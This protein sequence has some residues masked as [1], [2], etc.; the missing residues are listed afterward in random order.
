[1]A[2]N[3]PR[4]S[5]AFLVF[6][7]SSIA[8]A[9]VIIVVCALLANKP[10]VELVDAKRGQL[11]IETREKLE[12]INLEQ[13]TTAGWVDKEKGVVRLPIEDAM[14]LVAANLGGKKPAP[15]TV[16]I[17]P[18]LPM[19]APYDPNAAEPAPG[20]LPS[21]PQGSDTIRFDRP[22]ATPSA[23]VV[24]VPETLTASAGPDRAPL[25]HWTEKSEPKK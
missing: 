10:K 12:K 2:D 24:P 20:A 19:P 15:S 5:N 8:L 3:E 18:P 22:A 7:G 25:I 9:T 11:R 13:L 23:A 21:S 4:Q 16:K 17:D 1:M 6:L 14:R